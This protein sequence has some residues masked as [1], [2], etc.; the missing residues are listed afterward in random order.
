MVG[1]E[2]TKGQPT[3]ISNVFHPVLNVTNIRILVPLILDADKVQYTPWATLF[4]NTAKAFTV[5]DHIDPTINKPTDIDD[6]LWNRLDA[7]VLQ[8]LYS[9]IST[10]ILCKILDEEATTMVAWDRLHN[11]FQDNKGTR[12]V[13]L[14]NQFGATYLND[15]SSLVEYC[16]AL[17]TITMQL[18]AIGHPI[19]EACLVLQL[20]AH[21]TDEY[22]TIATIIQQ[23]NHLPSFDKACLM[24]DLDR[25]SRDKN[26]NGTSSSSTV[27][28]TSN[29][30]SPM[31]T[32]P[33]QQHP[34]GSGGRGSRDNGG[35]NNKGKKGP[36]QGGGH[37]YGRGVGH[38][39]YYGWAGP[40]AS[41]WDSP[42]CPYPTKPPQWHGMP[43]VNTHGL[44][45][46]AL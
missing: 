14:E 9:T 4:R 44:L 3:V 16:Q 13:H 40:W 6:D 7:I 15:F 19:S 25:M 32:T 24:L 45:G 27:L 18:S 41:Q 10:D 12:V 38:S 37:G 8:W 20:V 28:T 17:K 30:S 33:A 2:Q 31:S 1:D 22:A 21:L 42:P 5:L 23:S 39:P 46:P 36:S 11:L 26:K 29:T 43:S 35:R 34:S